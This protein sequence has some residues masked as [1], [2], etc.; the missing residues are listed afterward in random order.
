MF[1]SA[2]EKSIAV[3]SNVEILGIMVKAG[4]ISRMLLSGTDKIGRADSE[5]DRY[6]MVIQK[7]P[8]SKKVFRMMFVILA[9]AV[10]L[11]ITG[12]SSNK[13]EGGLSYIKMSKYNYPGS[14]VPYN[15]D[16]KEILNSTDCY[17]CV[18]EKNAPSD[19]V[20]PDEY[21]GLP[22]SIVTT[23]YHVKQK[24][25]YIPEQPIDSIQFGKNVLYIQNVFS[26]GEGSGIRELVIPESVMEIYYSFWDLKDAK[27]VV[28]GDP[29]VDNTFMYPDSVSVQTGSIESM[30]ELFKDMSGLFNRGLEYKYQVGTKEILERTADIDKDALFALGKEHFC[31]GLD[32]T[33]MI[34][35]TEADDYARFLDGPVITVER[36]PEIYY[37]DYLEQDRE[38]LLE[39]SGPVYLDI[40]YIAARYTDDIYEFEPGSSADKYFIIEKTGGRRVDYF[41]GLQPT[42]G[43]I[44]SETDYKMCYRI[45]VRSIKDDELICWFETIEGFAPETKY[46]HSKS[47][48]EGEREYLRDEDN[49]ITTPE[50]CLHKY[51]K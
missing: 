31:E 8:I 18:I 41:G 33:K 3:E 46:E 43:M 2:E 16:L 48:T 14:L 47:F 32:P 26:H 34:D 28:E 15:N 12:C 44:P 36:C 29:K 20:I 9:F 10:S 4:V 45:S 19:I 21:E 51:F 13:P 40:P 25:D 1:R 22:V 5:R 42:I 23:R 11:S 7:K 35:P 50:Y 49:N 37:S 38:K 27:V 6:M 30:N 17:I 39:E 24:Q